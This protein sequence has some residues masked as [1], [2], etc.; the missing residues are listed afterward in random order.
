MGVRILVIDDEPLILKTIEKALSKSG[1]EVTTTSSVEEFLSSVSSGGFDLLIM[2]V[3]LG[4]S[5]RTLL[6]EVKRVSP[7][8]KILTVSGSVDGSVGS[9]FLQKPF[10]IEEL[11]DK[12]RE[13]LSS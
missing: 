5:T 2:D 4:A 12:V 11:R 8:V 7:E 6:G 1:Y 3:H 10:R 13:M 9:P